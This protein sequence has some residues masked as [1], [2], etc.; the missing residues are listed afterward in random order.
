[1]TRLTL[2]FFVLLPF[3]TSA[4]KVKVGSKHFN[5]GYILSEIISQLLESKGVEVERIYNL[6]G[7][8]VSFEALNQGEIDIYP[9]YT[10]TIAME[11]LKAGQSLPV[12]IINDS[13]KTRSL[14]ISQP[15]G[16][17]NTYALVVSGEVMRR[18]NLR[19]IEDLKNISSLRFGLSYEFMKRADGWE[20]LS[21]V[22]GLPQVP[23]SLEHGL[24]Y[25]AIQSARIDV[26][27]AYSTDGEIAQYNLTLLKDNKNFFPEYQ[28]VSFYTIKLSDRVKN[29]LSQLDGQISER[30]MRQMN[31][32]VVFGKKDFAEVAQNFLIQKSLIDRSQTTPS[33]G[34]MMNK[35]VTHLGLTFLSLLG[36][37]VL[38]IPLGIFL[39]WNPTTAKY[40]VY[41]AGLLQTIPS[42]ALLAIL[43][44]VTG[45]G[46]RPAVIA[47][48]LYALLPILRNT[49][50]GLQ[51]VDGSLKKV[52]FSMGMSKAQQM[53]WVE[54]PLAVPFILSGV[55]TAAVIN[56]GTATL[57]AFIG[58]GGLGDYIVT[59]LALNN[60]NLILKGAI[61]AAVLA[62]VVELGFEGINY[63]T[64]PRFKRRHEYS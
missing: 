9:E 3:V 2:F 30:D 57:A 56:I 7:T 42:I 26:T 17:N 27:D 40:V 36:A 25:E 58:A 54:F 28:A 52:A 35:I 38:A 39:Y 37:M 43:I 32:Q 23:S 14:E 45:I 61:P 50:T 53:R 60:T 5:E 1:M 19:T 49:I 41:M 6:G 34:D 44:P 47:L 13:L 24:A 18:H 20:R 16:F 10:G 12:E 31:E 21:R 4:Q 64:R 51:Q 63:L 55:R 62:I 8:M 46:A 11:I 33:S 59:G 15:F 48:F 29:I 22:Y